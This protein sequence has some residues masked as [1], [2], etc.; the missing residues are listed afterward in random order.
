MKPGRRLISGVLVL[1][2]TVSMVS[3]VQA[4]NINDMKN[5]QQ[6]LE[7]QQKEAES[8]KKSLAARVQ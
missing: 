4:K 5:Q 7:E 2:L 6:Q 8:E 1:V 3:A